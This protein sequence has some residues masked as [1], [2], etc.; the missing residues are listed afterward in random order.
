MTTAV[1]LPIFALVTQ[2]SNLG[3][4]AIPGLALLFSSITTP[5]ALLSPPQSLK[6]LD[7]RTDQ[8]GNGLGMLKRI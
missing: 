1:K 5:P 7:L 4:V 6:G 2:G 8:H 3:I